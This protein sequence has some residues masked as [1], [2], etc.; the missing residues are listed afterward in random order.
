MDDPDSVATLIDGTLGE[1]SQFDVTYGY[2]AHG[3]GEKTACLPDDWRD[4]AVKFKVPSVPDTV[5]ICPEVN[6]IALAKLCAWREKDRVWLES[7]LLK[8]VVK[9]DLLRGRAPL[10]TNPNAPETGEITRRVDTL[11]AGPDR[12]ARIGRRST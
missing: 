11:G 12:G 2:Y 5:C 3:V 6:D 9:L 8:G 4:R 7:A 1:G 10:I